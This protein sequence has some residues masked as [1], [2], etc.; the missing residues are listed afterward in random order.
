MN[1]SRRAYGERKG[2]PIGG[3]LVV[4]EHGFFFAALLEDHFFQAVGVDGLF[5]DDA[6]EAFEAAAFDD[7]VLVVIERDHQD[8]RQR[9]PFLLY[10]L[11]ERVAVHVGHDPVAQDEVEGLR[12]DQLHRVHAG[13]RGPDGAGSTAQRSFCSR[14]LSEQQTP[15]SSSTTRSLSPSSAYAPIVPLLSSGFGG[16]F[17]FKS[18]IMWPSWY[19]RVPYSPSSA[20]SPMRRV[21]DWIFLRCCSTESSRSD[22]TT[23]SS[24]LAT[25]PTYCCRRSTWLTSTSRELLISCDMPTAISASVSSCSRRRMPR[26]SFA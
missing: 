4:L 16:C 3:S 14:A 23:N 2:S 8:H 17:S 26:M 13:R 21:I 1:G 10:R 20:I 6:L 24:S 7:V 18:A 25:R 5:E 19:S 12:L 22:S 11:V 9:R 15:R